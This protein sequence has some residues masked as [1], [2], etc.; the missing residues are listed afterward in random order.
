M[1]FSLTR[2]NVELFT[3][4][5]TDNADSVSSEVKP[6][7]RDQ[8]VEYEQECPGLQEIIICV[9]YSMGNA[10]PALALAGAMRLVDHACES[11]VFPG[12][13]TDCVSTAPRYKSSK[14]PWR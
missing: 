5:K 8:L 7:D 10:G 13:S 1:S 4:D 6:L 12:R 3:T 2:E 11:D 14:N 9:F